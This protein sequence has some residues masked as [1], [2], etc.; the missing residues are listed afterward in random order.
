VN[1][2]AEEEDSDGDKIMSDSDDD[3]VFLNPLLMQADSKKKK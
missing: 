3:G 1:F 2:K